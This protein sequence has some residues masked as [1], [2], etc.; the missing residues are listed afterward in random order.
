[1]RGARSASHEHR[2]GFRDESWVLVKAIDGVASDQ[3]YREA[4]LAATEW[5]AL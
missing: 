2:L 3:V 5:S 4:V 1:M